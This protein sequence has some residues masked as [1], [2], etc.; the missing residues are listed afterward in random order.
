MCQ[1]E[2]N[3]A[4]RELEAALKS[5]A[6]AAARIDP[7]AAAFAAGQRSG[8]RQL[9]V[10]QAAAAALLLVGAGAWLVPAAHQPAS[11]R[12]VPDSAVALHDAIPT[13]VTTDQSL[14]LLRAAVAEHGLDALPRVELPATEPMW[15]GGAINTRGKP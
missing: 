12:G 8:R 3:S 13:R 1:D 11:P 4:D 10:W 15:V 5:L 7:V 9:R 14:I 2:L 6:P